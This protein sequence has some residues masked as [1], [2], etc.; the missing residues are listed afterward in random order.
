MKQG[1]QKSST[2]GGKTKAASVRNNKKK[3]RPKGLMPR[4]KT[5]QEMNAHWARRA[6]KI[7]Q[8]RPKAYRP[9]G[10]ES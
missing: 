1:K 9:A 2:R 4:F 8:R 6:W 10:A 3:A 5:M 7:I